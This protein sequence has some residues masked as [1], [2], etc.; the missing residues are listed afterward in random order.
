M[1]AILGLIGISIA[2]FS[3]LFLTGN[4]LAFAQNSEN[5]LTSQNF[6]IHLSSLDPIGNTSNSSF[7]SS[8]TQ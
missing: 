6:R 1:R 8:G 3:L 4:T 5:D 7:S 2:A